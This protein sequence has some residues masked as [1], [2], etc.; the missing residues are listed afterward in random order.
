VADGRQ[1]SRILVTGGFGFIGGH[2]LERLLAGPDVQVH[3]VDDLS[4]NPV[5]HERLLAELGNPARLTYDL[6]SIEDYL[7]GGAGEFDSIVHLAAPVG[8]AG[9][10]KDG[11]RIVSKVVADTYLLADWALLHDARLLD[12]STSEV[13]GGG[14][15]GLCDEEDAKIV[16]AKTTFRLE[17]A[18]AKLAAETALVNLH[19]RDG[20]DVVIVRPFN[21]AGPR[22]S[23]EGGFVL[24]RFTAQAMKGLPLTIFGSGDARRTFTHVRETADGIV[25]ALERGTPGIAYN[26]GN[27]RNVTTVDR[28]AD[29]VLEVTGSTSTKRYVDP[30]EIYGPHFAEANDKFPSTGRAMTELGWN[31]TQGVTEVASAAY[32]YMKRLPADEFAR[33]AGGQVMQQLHEAHAP[34]TR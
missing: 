4:S 26:L 23:G 21:V 34:V 6:C 16:P 18:V 28:L 13:Y 3:V 22:Q 8:P 10:L 2:L 14:R 9:I 17:Y 20:L 33:L 25:R 5:P 30:A 15:D 11:G 1:S 12:V 24:P 29:V 31:P 32:E 19:A 7:G 27:H